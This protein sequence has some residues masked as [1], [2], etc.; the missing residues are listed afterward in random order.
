MEGLDELEPSIVVWSCAIS[1]AENPETLAMSAWEKPGVQ[2]RTLRIGHF[3]AA[4][5]EI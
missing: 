1:S 4:A 5:T 2:A 3:S